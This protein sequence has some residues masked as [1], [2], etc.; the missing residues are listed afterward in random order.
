M[1]EKKEAALHALNYII[2]FLEKYNLKWAITG[3]FACFVYGV[4]R[5]ITDIDIDIDTSKDKT[6][7]QN[8]MNDLTERISQPMIHFVDQNYDNYNFEITIEGQVIDICPMKEMNVFD[9][10]TGSY[11]PFYANG[12]PEIETVEWNG[13]KIPLLS[14]RLIIKN[15]E[16]LPFQRESDLK[17]IEGLKKLLS[18]SQS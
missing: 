4:P 14:K 8:F 1:V 12:F 11:Q 16:M 18:L 13:L 15:K 7:F 10:N 17:D 5:E 9:K 2:P 6:E 3:G